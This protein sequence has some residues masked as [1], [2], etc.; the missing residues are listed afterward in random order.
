MNLILQRYLLKEFFRIFI[1]T[2]I[3]LEFLLILGMALQSLHKGVNI[4]ALAELAPHIFFYSLPTA[5]PVALLA[6]TVITYGRLSGDNELW[7]MLTSGVHLWIIVLPVALLGLL[8]SLLSLGMN[9]ELLP[10][11]YRMLRVLQERAVQEIL[12]QTV[13]AAQGKMRLPPYYVYIRSAEGGL[14]KDIIIMET[15]GEKVSSI[16]L[17]DEGSLTLDSDNNL[18]LFAMKKGEFIKINPKKADSQSPTATPTAITFDETLFKVPLGLTE[19]TKFKKYA[20]LRELFELKKNVRNEIREL[21]DVP[22]EK[23]LTRRA[24]KGRLREAEEACQKLVNERTAFQLGIVKSQETIAKEKAGQENLDNEI[25]VSE[26]YIR[27]AKEALGTLLLS[28]EL[29]VSAKPKQGGPDDR[30]IK[31]KEL[32]QTIEREQSRTERAEEQKQLAK[33]TIRLE[34]QNLA[35]YGAEVERL[36][37][38]EL[39]ADVERSRWNQILYLREKIETSRD[40]SVAIQ[41]RLYPAFSCLAFVLVGIPIGIMSRRGNILIGILITFVIILVIYYPLVTIVKVLA[42]DI[43]TPVVLTLWGPN[44]VI[45]AI[46]VVLLIK[47]FR[48]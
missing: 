10:K 25:K 21:K 22:R 5:L 47:V 23:K 34:E 32:T 46:A 4:T 35:H 36:N 27:I 11:S 3:I 40:I 44:V 16:I 17:A 20:S 15:E 12:A 37:A 30:D 19:W 8:F 13:G 43:R 48:K 9:A 31:I 7:A 45:T 28:K 6:T 33:E 1:P 39:N 2:I 29:T 26:N 14:L 42:A 24:V 18:I 38:L 41:N